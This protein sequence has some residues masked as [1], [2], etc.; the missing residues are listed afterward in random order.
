MT[1]WSQTNAGTFFVRNYLQSEQASELVSDTATEKS[2]ATSAIATEESEVTSEIATETSEVTSEIVAHI[3]MLESCTSDAE[4]LTGLCHARTHKCSCVPCDTAGCGGCGANRACLFANGD[5]YR[6]RAPPKPA[7]LHEACTRHELCLSGYC[8][9]RLHACQCQVCNESGCG[10]CPKNKVCITL[11]GKDVNRC[12]PI[13]AEPTKSPEPTRKITQAPTLLLKPMDQCKNDNECESKNC[14]KVSSSFPTGRCQCTPCSG[15]GCGGCQS[16]FTCS[17]TDIPGMNMCTFADKPIDE[18]CS[19][20]AECRSKSCYIDDEDWT[21][22]HCQ[23]KVCDTPGCSEDCA[24][25]EKCVL[26]EGGWPND[27]VGTAPPSTSPSTSPPTTSPTTS[28]PSTS[29]TTPPPTTS[30]TAE[31][32]SSSPSNAPTRGPRALG[33]LCRLGRHCVSGS[34]FLNAA[35]ISKNLPGVC[36]CNPD[37]QRNGCGD[38]FSCQSNAAIGRRNQ[39]VRA[40]VSAAPTTAPTKAP[41]RRKRRPGEACRSNVLCLYGSCFRTASQIRNR[42]AGKCECSQLGGC[43]NGR[44]CVISNT[45]K[46]QCRL[47]TQSPTR[48]N[49]NVGQLCKSDGM[50]GTGSCFI[51]PSGV[52]VCQC[53]A[54]TARGCGSGRRCVGRATS[55]NICRL[56]TV[57]NNVN[58]SGQQTVNNNVNNNGQQRVNNNANN[59]GQQKNNNNANN[60]GQQKNNNNANNNGQQKNNNNAN[61]NG[62]QKNNNNANNNGQQKNNNNANNNGQQKNNN[63]NDNKDDKDKTEDNKNN[64]D[65]ENDKDKDSKNDKDDNNNNDKDDKDN[66]NDKNDKDKGK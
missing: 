3:Q 41:T 66:K 56:Q 33:V 48:G 37:I 27:C 47:P 4:C 25:F 28:P 38:N 61:N 65:S 31:M 20:N 14:F 49:R 44:T 63:N 18:Y 39:C 15:K 34:C 6:C 8:H 9:E 36:Q 19:K 51:R 52:G 53:R 11:P 46:N 21:Y 2:G 64:K 35:Q 17:T 23:C 40:A 12:R 16:G 55:V 5:Q 50:C 1:L 57:N 54:G 7:I 29:P 26:V 13:T 24:A 45:A 22:N 58:N 42:V 43:G 10:G 59:N 60:N 30:P 32:P 62:Q